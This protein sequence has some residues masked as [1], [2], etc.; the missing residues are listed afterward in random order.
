MNKMEN[1]KKDN[2]LES[3]LRTKCKEI[4]DLIIEEN[5]DSVSKSRE[6]IISIWADIHVLIKSFTND[7]D[8]QKLYIEY[9]QKLLP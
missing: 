3:Q 4:S 8:E 9:V 1:I 6:K 7:P 2:I 5:P